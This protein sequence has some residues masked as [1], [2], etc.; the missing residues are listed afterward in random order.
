MF[1]NA[2]PMFDHK[3]PQKLLR[4]QDPEIASRKNIE[5]YNV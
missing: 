2:D 3:Y 5:N 4:V 1:I